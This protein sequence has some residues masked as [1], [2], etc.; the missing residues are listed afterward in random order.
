MGSSQSKHGHFYCK[1]IPLNE[2]ITLKQMPKQKKPIMGIFTIKVH[3][4]FTTKFKDFVFAIF[5]IQN[6][7][8]INLI[9]RYWIIQ[10][11]INFMMVVVFHIRM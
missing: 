1:K 2:H 9:E 6:L 5:Q 3:H 8:G 4:F 7:N 10:I 11:M